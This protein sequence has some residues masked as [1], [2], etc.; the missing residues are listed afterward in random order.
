MSEKIEKLSEITLSEVQNYEKTFSESSRAGFRDTIIAVAE[1]HEDG[2]QEFWLVCRNS[3]PTH[4]D[5][6]ND[7]VMFASY[8]SPNGPII[9][10]SCGFQKKWNGSNLKL[11]SKNYFK[12]KSPSP[13]NVDCIENKIEVLGAESSFIP[14]LS[15]FLSSN[16]AQKAKLKKKKLKPKREVPVVTALPDRPLL[17]RVQDKIFRKLITDPILILGAPGTGKTTVQVKRLS[18]KTKWEFLSKEEKSLFPEGA[19]TDNSGWLFFTPTILLKQYL[20]E[21][22]S[23]EQLVTSDENVKVWSDHRQAILMVLK[24]IGPGRKTLGRHRFVALKSIDS[25]F[26]F[27]YTVSFQE[28]FEKS[29]LEYIESSELRTKEN[30]DS[31]P[32]SILSESG[33]G[34]VFF[35]VIED[36]VIKSYAEFRTK[37]ATKKKYLKKGKEVEEM[38]SSKK[39][40]VCSEE[41]DAILYVSLKFIFDHW[42]NVYSAISKAPSL[43]QSLVELRRNFISIDEASDFS[44]TQIGCISLLCRLG[45]G[46]G[47]TLSGD[48]MQRMTRDGI[49]EWRE[50]EKIGLYCKEYTLETPYRQTKRLYGF[51]RKVHDHFLDLE[52]R[53]RSLKKP[54]K[55]ERSDPKILVYSNSSHEEQ[56]DWIS[57]RITEIFKLSDNRLPT[58]GVV[59]PSEK[60]IAVTTNSLSERLLNDSFEV[61]GSYKGQSL[62]VESKVRVFSVEHVKGI[63]FEAVFFMGFDEIIKIHPHLWGKFLYVG[64]SRSRKFLALTTNEKLP[65]SMKF[66]ESKI[67]SETSFIGEDLALSWRSYLD[68]DEVEYSFSQSEQFVLDSEFSKDPT[69]LEE[70]LKNGLDST[71]EFLSSLKLY[72]Y[73]SKDYDDIDDITTKAFVRF[74]TMLRE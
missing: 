68:A 2:K 66:L 29:A 33:G 8:F 36:L 27:D 6:V 61:E 50:L 49:E 41:L 39:I 21:S 24:Y 13:L 58:L 65:D 72:D 73:K 11:F 1:I 64:S 18:Q 47:L 51:T 63:E 10:E 25:S 40:Q 71:H 45:N 26:V 48:I 38:L 74:G 7:G 70:F 32:I 5:N 37:S 57:D 20:K 44:L 35:K 17:D 54:S 53:K 22:L 23:K 34:K 3:T 15:E 14:S 56:V 59:V 55:P 42:K 67:S 62:G 4:V 52:G 19:F 9:A 16:Q 46:V 12:T 60:E 31:G 43:V 69:L 28:F 30:S